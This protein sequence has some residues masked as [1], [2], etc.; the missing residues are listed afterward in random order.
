[1]QR[2]Q[3]QKIERAQRAGAGAQQR[4]R[5]D[6]RRAEDG[7]RQMPEIPAQR[8]PLGGDDKGDGGGRQAEKNGAQKID[9]L[10]KQVGQQQHAGTHERIP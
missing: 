4:E 5:R 1:M 9:V 8:G 7:E 2:L 3:P 10:R 6:Q